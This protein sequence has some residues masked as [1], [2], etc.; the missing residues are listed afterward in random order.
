M[1]PKAGLDGCGKSRPNGIRPWT[2]QPVAGRYTEYAV[3]ALNGPYICIIVPEVLI[4][5]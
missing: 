1:G 3:P 4:D 2:I 5:E